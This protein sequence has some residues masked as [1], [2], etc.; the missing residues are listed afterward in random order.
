MMARNMERRINRLENDLSHISQSMAR[1]EERV[2]LLSKQV[3][4]LWI[5]LTITLIA[6]VLSILLH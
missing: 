3:Q 1:L 2:C 6:T 5:P 4:Y